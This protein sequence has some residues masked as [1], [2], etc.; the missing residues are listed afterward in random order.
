MSSAEQHTHRSIGRRKGLVR[1][2]LLAT[3]AVAI[4]TLASI[5]GVAH[6]YSYLRTS[7]LTGGREGAYFALGTRLAARASRARGRVTVVSTAGS[8]DN[9]ARLAGDDR[10]C[11]AAFAFVQDG[12]P[13]PQG[14]QIE[15]LGRLPEPESL[16]LLGKR[17]RAFSTFADL[18]GASIGI[19]PE[20]SGTAHLMRQLFQDADLK[21]LEIRFSY[22]GLE[23][24]LELV[25]QRRL[26]LA[27]IV[28]E[29][30]AEF[31]RTAIRRHDLDIAAPRELEGLVKRHAWLGH[32]RIPAGRYDVGASHPAS[33]EVRSTDRYLGGGQPLRA[34]G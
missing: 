20:G 31:I 26:D 13:V 28:M 24:Q 10:N 29:E 1:F 17:G 15:V 4:A 5:F 8:V 9:L 16:L 6:D 30:H 32:G 22:H 3:V 7:L 14:A 34:A 21:A 2:L 27:A 19:G 25:G 12:T 23:E 11:A 33:G 18:R